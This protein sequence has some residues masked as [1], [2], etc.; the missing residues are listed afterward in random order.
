MTKTGKIFIDCK[1]K[2]IQNKR[3]L[4]YLNYRTK[5]NLPIVVGKRGGLSIKPPNSKRRRYITQSCK[6]V[7]N[8][9]MF[10]ITVENM[11]KKMSKKKV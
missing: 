6:K 7:R 1:T 3:R 10:W 11:K 9:A 8:N 5:K 2:I 4:Q